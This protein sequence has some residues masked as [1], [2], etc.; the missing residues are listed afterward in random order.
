MLPFIEQIHTEDQMLTMVKKCR[1]CLQY[2][3]ILKGFKEHKQLDNYWK[4][5]PLYYKHMLVG[6]LPRIVLE[7]TF[8][9]EPLG[10]DINDILKIGGEI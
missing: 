5:L 6:C 3:S 4:M 7:E 2:E 1:L 9:I 10:V 8:W